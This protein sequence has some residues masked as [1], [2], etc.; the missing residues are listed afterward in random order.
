MDRMLDL[1]RAAL[2]AAVRCYI[3]DWDNFTGNR[4]KNGYFYRRPTDGKFEFHH[5]DSD[6]GFQ[7]GYFNM[8]VP[9]TVGGT[10]WTN[11]TGTP[12]FRHYV[13][14]YLTELLQKYT[15]NS[16]RMNAF[17]DANNYQTGATDPL[18]PFTLRTSSVYPAN[19]GDVASRG[20]EVYTNWWNRREAN[21]IT[22]INTY[23]GTNLTRPYSISTTNNQTVSTPTFTINGEAPSSVW[24]VD[25]LGHPEGVFAWVPTT[26]NNALW[27]ITN[28]RL[29][30]GLNAL[31]VRFLGSDGS[32]LST[33]PFNVTL[34]GNAPPLVYLTV[35]PGSGNLTANELVTLDATGSYDP[36]GTALT[37][38]WTITPTAGA[39]IAHSVPGKTEARFQIPGVYSVSLTV[40]D[41]GGAATMVTRELTVTNGS[42]FTSF[43]SSAGLDPS[44][45]VQNV[46]LRDDFSPSNWY[47]L[48][49]LSG[50]LLIQVLDDAAKPLGNPTFTHPLITRDVPDASDFTLQTEL[51]PDTREFGNYLTGLWLDTVESGVSTKYAFGI[52]G[53]SNLI[54]S[55]AASGA[56]GQVSSTSIT[57][58]GALLRIRRV[59]PNLLFQ[60]GLSGVWTTFYTQAIPAGTIAGRGGIFVATTTATT[61]R[62][63]FDYLLVADPANTNS[64]LASLRICEVMYNP[65]PTGVEYIELCNYGAQTINL[66][67]CSFDNTKPFALFTFGNEPLQPGE[68]ICIT[69]NVTAFQAKYGTSIRLAGAWTSGSL[70]NGGEQIILRDATANE[71]HN[72]TYHDNTDPTWPAAADG[73]GPSL[74]I[75]DPQ[76]NYDLGSNWRASAETAGSPGYL[77]LG[78]DT[79]GDGLA[80]IIEARFGTDPAN[81]GSTPAATSARAMDGS[82]N[83]SF[84]TVNGRSY[85][86]EYSTN[87]Q[88]WLTLQTLTA[89]GP[90]ASTND[91]AILTEPH[92][93]Y[94]VVALP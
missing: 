84:P 2:Y 89:T 83:I 36:E 6:L 90:S 14:F 11:L 63:A 71:I 59:G 46:E 53:S 7:T 1:K 31:T 18:A 40:T 8:A 37:Y 42:D 64:V 69:E 26:V 29:A 76:G 24:S 9:G 3:G 56:W 78:P 44:Y 81:P 39:T 58:S 33:L 62:V 73:T 57:G 47:S 43:G 15:K 60:R 12:L 77:G 74:E 67:G 52:D 25:V 5:W 32:I 23:G 28:L 54:V 91:T 70:S 4:G 94:R 20:L 75:I 86:V 21:I 82:V 41:V 72:F 38:N 16:A 22:Q 93:Y 79:D 48:A 68:T 35:S 30:N 17:L 50:R 66:Q 85:R 61:V 34:T 80:D 88:I 65:A 13:N 51:E 92:R 45:T 49:D 19:D 55:R 27:T 87:L 10:G